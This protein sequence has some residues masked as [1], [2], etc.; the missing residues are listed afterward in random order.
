M[1]YFWSALAGIVV[2]E[3]TTIALLDGFHA[4]AWIAGAA[5]AVVSLVFCVSFLRAVWP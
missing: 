1:R 2:G 4:Q 3:A 5:G